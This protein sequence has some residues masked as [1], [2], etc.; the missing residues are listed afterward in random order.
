M[1]LWIWQPPALYLMISVSID[2]SSRE[3][4][5]LISILYDKL[6]LNTRKCH[7]E[8][9]SVAGQLSGAAT[10]IYSSEPV[11]TTSDSAIP[12]RS[13]LIGYGCTQESL[14]IPVLK[15]NLNTDC[16]QPCCAAHARRFPQAQARAPREGGVRKRSR[17]FTAL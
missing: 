6:F 7:R 17:I 10:V 8:S 13:V 5:D 3:G 11:M 9:V 2:A 14:K 15:T 12:K 1:H 4:Q 16:P